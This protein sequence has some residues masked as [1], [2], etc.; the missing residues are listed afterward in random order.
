MVVSLTHF[1]STLTKI[2]LTVTY[3][4]GVVHNSE[5]DLISLGET[6]GNGVA[7]V[8]APGAFLVDFLPILQYI[9]AWMPGAGFQRRLS[10]YKHVSET[11]TTYPF[12]MVKASLV[13]VCPY[14]AIV[15][16]Y[17]SNHR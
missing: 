2:I 3:G 16:I 7:D 13:C 4:V 5:I 11:F 10:F 1:I 6:I 12:A 15:D 8:G 14:H 17:I 9:P